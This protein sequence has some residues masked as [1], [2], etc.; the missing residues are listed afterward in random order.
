MRRVTLGTAGIMLAI[1]FTVPRAASAGMGEVIDGIIGLTGP[2][3]I[4]VPIECEVSF[5][6]QTATQKPTQTT[7][8][9]AAGIPIPRRGRAADDA[10]WNA[11]KFWASFG[12]G[13]YFSTGKDSEMREFDAFCVR[14]L[15]LE[16]TL[17]Y[18]T[19]DPTDGGFVLEHGAGPS[20]LH[21]SGSDFD[22][23]VKGGIKL[24]PAAL[25][26][27]R[28]LIFHVAYNVRIFPKAF[29]SEDFGAT[30]VTH[31]GREIAHGFTFGIGF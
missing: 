24:T 2:Q 13:V 22:S 3:M 29:T 7:T 17:N 27:R 11:R 20:F 19:V 1:V 8:C 5:A 9:Y 4:G 30:S 25:T 26:W 28:R 6:P 12:G 21:L 10:F 18:R 23:F 15:A 14:M 31:N 16:P